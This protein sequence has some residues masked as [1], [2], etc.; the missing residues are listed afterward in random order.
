MKFNAVVK[1]SFLTA[2]SCIE[3]VGIYGTVDTETA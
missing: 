3:G 2:A 1:D